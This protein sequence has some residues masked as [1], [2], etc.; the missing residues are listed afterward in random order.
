MTKQ[1]Q[2]ETFARLHNELSDWTK[3]QCL[4]GVHIV[5]IATVMMQFS[6]RI[7][8]ATGIPKEIFL[9]II[10]ELINGTYKAEG[11]GP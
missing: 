2:Q 7:A 6:A 11:N 5:D 8:S 10:V 9:P 4:D 1:L 3:Q